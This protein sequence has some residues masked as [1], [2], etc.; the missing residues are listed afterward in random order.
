MTTDFDP[1][2][3]YA[4][5][6][7]LDLPPTLQAG[8]YD[9]QAEAERLILA[10]VIAKLQPRPGD[11]LLDIGAGAGLLTIPLSFMVDAVVAMDHPGVLARLRARFSDGTVQLLPGSFPA[12]TPKGLFDRIVAYSVIQYVSNVAAAADFV[13]AAARLLNP[14]GRLLIADLPNRD[15]KARL[16]ASARAAQVDRDWVERKRGSTT[17]PELRRA[18]DERIGG[19]GIMGTFSDADVLALVAALRSAG[20]NAT[21]AAQDENLPFGLTR[22]DLIVSRF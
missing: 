7:R 3:G 20:F 5:A 14:G 21:I 6:A 15:V 9:I 22:E 1:A 12:V 18:I 16:G 19:A 13:C 11:R 8:R 17:P 2:S 4:E 10:D